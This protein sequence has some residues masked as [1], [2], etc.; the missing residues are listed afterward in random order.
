MANQNTSGG[1]T[2]S[3]DKDRIGDIK[4]FHLPKGSWTYARNAINNSVSGDLGDIGNEPS[5]LLCTSAPYTIIGTIHL[6]ADKWAIFSTDDTDSEIGLFAEDACSYTTVVNDPCLNF[7]RANLV[8]GQAKENFDCSWQIYWSDQRRNPDRSMNMDK[9]PFLENCVTV[10]DCLICTPTTNLDCDKIRLARLV[11][12][13][14]LRVQKG[15]SGGSLLN[16]SYFAL[17]YYTINGQKITDYFPASNVQALFDH[18]NAASSLDI[19]IGDIDDSFE[20]FGLVLVSTVNQQTV[21]RKLGIYNTRQSHVTVDNLSNELPAVPIEQIPLRTPVFDASDA[22]YENGDYLIRVGPTTKLDFNYQPLANQIAAKWV[23]VEYPSNYYQKGGNQAGHMRDEVYPFF[24]RWVY[25]TGDRSASYHIPGRAS[26]PSDLTVV[27]GPDAA[28]EIA[29]GITPFN[30]VVRNTASVTSLATVALPDGGT[31]I[32]EGLMGYWESTELY[33]DNLPQIWDDLCG[34]PI[35]HHRF[36]DNALHPNVNHFN[37][38]ASTIRIM[39]V[40]FEN[41]QVPLDNLGN[42]ITNIV[43]YEIL[44]GSREGNKT[45]IAKGIINNTGMYNIPGGVTPRTGLYPNYPYNDLNADKFIS[46]TETSFAAVG[47]SVSGYIPNPLFSRDTFTFHSPDTQFRNPF[48][49]SRELKIYGELGGTA[50]GQFVE[51]DKHPKHKLLTD[52]AFYISVIAGVGIAMIAMNGKRRTIRTGPKAMNTGLTG[53]FVGTSSGIVSAPGV[54]GTGAPEGGVLGIGAVTA[55]ETAFTG[56]NAGFYDGGGILTGNLAGLSTDPYYTTL[57]AAG[58][59]L[60]AAPGINGYSTTVDQEDGQHASIPT[61][62]RVAQAVATFTYYLSEGADNVARI[63]K[64]LIPYRQYALQYQSHCPYTI[65]ATPQVNNN[66]RLITESAYLGEGLQDFGTGFRVNNLHRG[67]SVVLNTSAVVADPIGNDNTRQRVGDTPGTV[68][69]DN[70]LNSFSTFSSCHYAALKQRMRNQYGQIDGV[71]QVMSSTCVTDKTS[72]T[73]PVLFNGDTYVTRYTEKNTMPFFYDWMYGQPDGYEFN[74]LLKKNVPHPAYWMDT[75][76]FDTTEFL[77]SVVSNILSPGS[78]VTPSDRH[79]LDRAGCP[80]AF[81]V[82]KAYMYLFSSGVRDFFVESEINTDLRDWGEKDS[83]RHYDPY[84]Y[85]DLKQL[86]NT[87]IIK[88]GNFFKYDFSLSVSRLFSN[89]ISWGNTQD[90]N[91]DPLIAQTCFSYYPK[92]LIY[93]LPQQLELRKDNWYL[94]PANNYKDFKSRVTTIR[95]VGK[96]GA[97]ILFENESPVQFL[98]VDTLQTDSGTKITLGDGGL[99]S[100]AL[101]NLINTDEPIEYGS[102]QNRLSVINTPAGLFWMSQNQGKIFSLEGGVKEISNDDNKWWFANYLPYMLTQD[103]PD[104]ELTDNPVIGIGCQAIYDNENSLVYFTKRDF[105][106]RRDINNLVTYISRDDFMVDGTL[107]VKL[108]DP[109]FF[110]DASWTFSYDPKTRGWISHHDW[111]PNLLL[112]S[113]QT[114]MSIRD[115][116]IWIHNMVCNSYCNFYGVDYPFEVEFTA[117]TGQQVNTLRSI[118]Y[119]MEAY[120][121]AE[122]CY[123]RFHVLDFNFDEAVVHNTEQCSGV[124]RLN[125]SPKNN[126]IALLQYP[127]INPTFIDILFSKEENKYRFNQFWDITDDRG[128]FNPSAQRMIWNTTANGYVRVLNPAN[129]N[130]NKLQLERKKFRHYTTSVLLRRRVSGTTKMLFMLANTKTLYSPR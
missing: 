95:P 113:K 36:P 66:R 43:G 60:S 22:I 50:E 67:R 12:S 96:N 102:C 124:L 32:A 53:V 28:I 29:E 64:T 10:D 57:S 35:R 117:P 119:I 20:E 129:L 2:N 91:Y 47:C 5:N 4:D 71:R 58:I 26:V 118:E 59:P 75:T 74:Y 73:S 79:V 70:P 48:L 85:T 27:A 39:G 126:P 51:P 101:Q 100:Q 80:V 107:P 69:H 23:S 98:G 9:P 68:D 62:L 108:G 97:I 19:F 92:R 44:R 41:I 84:R 104:F 8:T 37:F 65:F 93:S 125:L 7:N 82:K 112:P 34:K 11:K 6:Y 17:V 46:L 130:Y 94:Y 99:F 83:E 15:S 30:W 63:I 127:A 88:S 40:K 72:S 55:Y 52:L 42:P 45:V 38:G 87:A 115:N 128:E 116:G 89:F 33:P 18:D 3:F 122:N 1:S 31:Q 21:A 14:C 76:D 86:F 77:Q 16:G 56:A 123:D 25:N 120:R 13:P 103:Y 111:H 110:E 105:R 49:S 81:G 121:Y 54:T 90:R 24:I 109:R 106:R 61:P 114:F 78:W